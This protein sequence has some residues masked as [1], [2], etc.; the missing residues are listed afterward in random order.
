MELQNDYYKRLIEQDDKM[1]C[2]R[3]DMNGNFTAMMSF[4]GEICHLWY[5]DCLFFVHRIL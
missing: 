2:F 1:R 5:Q 3:H 4:V